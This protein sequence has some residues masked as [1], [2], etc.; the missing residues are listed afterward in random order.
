[1]TGQKKVKELFID[2]K[3]P[4][5]FRCRIPILFCGETLLWV[6]GIRRSSAASLTTG[7]KTVARAEILDFTP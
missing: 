2:A 4:L 3:V 7:T 5:A 6:G 1:M